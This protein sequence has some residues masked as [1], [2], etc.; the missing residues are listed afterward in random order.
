MMN[1][2]WELVNSLQVCKNTSYR[3]K[4]DMQRSDS[5]IMDLEG[6]SR[7]KRTSRLVAKFQGNNIDCFMESELSASASEVN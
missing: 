2:W 3:K 6:I 5:K 4:R 1:R 7:G